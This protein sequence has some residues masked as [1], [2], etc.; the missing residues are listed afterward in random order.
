MMIFLFEFLILSTEIFFGVY[1]TGK[2]HKGSGKKYA[3]L[4]GMAASAALLLC[5]YNSVSKALPSLP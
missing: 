3:V 1:L 2:R 5:F 4:G